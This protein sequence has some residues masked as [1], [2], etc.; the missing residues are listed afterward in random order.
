MTFKKVLSAVLAGAMV[1]SMGMTAFA[2]STSSGVTLESEDP[3]ELT[4]EGTTQVPA[5]KI[6]VPETASIIANPY[7]LSVDASSIGGTANES[8]QVISPVQ[9]I[10]NMSLVDVEVTAKAY[11][12]V[13][14]EAFFGSAATS[15]A[16]KFA[17]ISFEM[18]LCDGT[19]AP[20]SYT[21]NTVKLDT[22]EE[23]KAVGA[24]GLTMTKS[25]DGTAVA[26]TGAVGFH[27]TGDLNDETSTPWTEAD[28]FGAT[29][30]FDFTAK[31]NAAASGSTT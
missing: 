30:V 9:Y 29:I 14:G 22:S 7:R 8:G 5:L 20:A 6:V 1:L 23:G 16:D 25:T 10:K 24:A 21:A 26:A 3:Y 17:D 27:F 31:A 4:V 11:G 18:G 15:D 19:Q 2:T 28:T 13:D 12:Y